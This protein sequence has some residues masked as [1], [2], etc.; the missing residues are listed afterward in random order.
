MPLPDKMHALLLKK[1]GFAAKAEGIAFASME[2]YLEAAIT[3]VP[4]PGDGEVLI[5][6]IR[7]SI[8]P[9]DLHFIKGEYGHPPVAGTP[10]GFEAVGTVVTCG[11]GTIGEAL[12]GKRVAFI[13]D[14]SGAWAQYSLATAETCI[15]VADAVRDEDAAAMIV[16]PLTAV[17]MFNLVQEAQ[18]PSFILTAAASQLC[19]LLIGLGRKHDIAPI[20]IVRRNE[21]IDMLT[22]LGA[23]H[24]LNQLNEDFANQLAAAIS[25]EKPRVMLDA[26][27]DPVAGA[28]FTA[29]P[30]LAKWIIYG[31]LS[32]DPMLVDQPGQMIFM[33]KSIE[34]FWLT[35]W[36]RE[37]DQSARMA[38]VMTVQQMFMSGE[39][40]TDVRATIP[41]GE[42]IAR[43]PDE[44]AKAN[45]GKVMLT[46]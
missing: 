23:K 12:V 7:S 41:L 42:A 21:H 2:P 27:A 34:G 13:A 11:G 31:K 18:S 37:A 29:M 25:A 39:W 30:R 15:P 43:L 45:T 19:K 1:D 8:N 5:K 17:A 28:I 44:L 26:L 16:N 35:K 46:P 20:A 22:E 33:E 14:R 24:V 6:V 9:S 10:A 3:E 32:S 40:H 4:K 38:A 36:M